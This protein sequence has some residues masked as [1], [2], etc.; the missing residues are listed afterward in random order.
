MSRYNLLM[1][2][3][4]AQSDHHPCS[5]LS[6]KVATSKFSRLMLVYVADET[7]LSKTWSRIPKR[8]FFLSTM[9]INLLFDFSISKVACLNMWSYI[10]LVERRFC[11]IFYRF[12]YIHVIN[13]AVLSSRIDFSLLTLVLQ[14]T[15]RV[16]CIK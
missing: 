9:P 16:Y 13:A 11:L 15:T 14:Y 6:G 7:N 3:V 1:L 10:T 12:L 5:S 2:F 8:V 4:N